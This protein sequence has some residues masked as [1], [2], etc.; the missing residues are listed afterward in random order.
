MSDR[1]AVYDLGYVPYSG[2]RLGRR[3]A[4]AATYRDG[5]Y[6]VLGIKRRARKKIMPWALAILVIVPAVVFVGSAFLLSSF[7]PEAESPFASQQEYF[8]I[9]GTI[10]FLFVVL[11]APELLIPDRREGVLSIYSSRP[12]RPDD[13]VAA[14][15]AS[16]L[17][18]VAAFMLLPQLLM[19]IGF[20]ALDA[21][22]FFSAVVSNSSEIPKFVAASAVYA[23]AYA[24]L[25]LL[26]ATLADRKS[27]ATGVYLGAMIIGSSLAAFLVDSGTRYAALLGFAEHPT[28]VVEWIYGTSGDTVTERAGFDP[29]VAML[30]ITGLA[31]TSVGIMIWRYRRLM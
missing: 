29:W 8:S 23:L 17:T 18:M 19:Y 24:P 25:A 13:Y 21:D 26:I 2:E 14:R 7:A 11:A 9:T 15:S 22:G 20:S 3:G 6:R 12:L 30:V 1:G 31:V 16:L 4:I 28:H 10:I 5:N 27:V